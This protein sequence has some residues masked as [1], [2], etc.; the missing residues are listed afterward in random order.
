MNRL[1]ARWPLLLLLGLLIL[2]LF[3]ALRAAATT[4]IPT[5]QQQRSHAV[6]S[7]VINEVDVDTPGADSAEFIELYDGGVGN[8]PL[9]GLVLVLYNG[10]TDSSYAAFDLDG[11]STNA[12]G[13]IVI[14]N[15]GVNLVSATFPTDTLQQGADAV[16]LFQSD[17]TNFGNGTPITTTNLLDALIYDT[18]DPDDNGL[19][20][21]LNA[22]QPQI[23]EAGAGDSTAVSNQRCPNG[24]G[25]QRN[26]TTYTQ[27]FPS[28]GLSNTCSG[29]TPTATATATP[30]SA[31]TP[32]PTVTPTST[33]PTGVGVTA[34]AGATGIVG[35]QVLLPLQIINNNGG[36]SLLG[37]EFQLN[38]NPAVLESL[39][40]ST[41]NTLSADWQVTINNTTP[42]QLHVAG[43]GITPFS[44][45]GVL[46]NLHFQVTQTVN[47]TSALT[48]GDF[49]WNEG[50]PTASTQAGD[51]RTRMLG[52]GGT[53]LYGVS[54]EPVPQVALALTGAQSANATTN[55]QGAYHF[56]LAGT[57][58]ISVTLSKTGDNG[59][60]L[61]ALDA[62]WIL[63]CTVN[64]RPT[65][66]C[67]L[68]AGDSS[69]DGQVSA[70]DAALIARH[71]VGFTTPPSLAGQWRF[72]PP[73]RS[74]PTLTT[75]LPQEDYTAYLVGDV[76]GNWV[77]NGT[78][79]SATTIEPTALRSS[80]TRTGAQARMALW[81]DPMVA[82][83]GYQLTVQYNPATVQFSAVEPTSARSASWQSVANT[84][85]PGVVQV[86]G[87]GAAPLSS[88]DGEVM[89]TLLFQAND[90][91]DPTTDLWL[92]T[93]QIN[94]EQLF[95]PPPVLTA[96]QRLFFPLVI[97]KQ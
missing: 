19:L 27:G 17:A 8:T 36:T 29:A 33:P 39:G 53:V 6:T 21:L 47:V 87:Y 64:L 38:Y 16:A 24:S 92:Q 61:S 3:P 9:N 60:A 91:F 75:D 1:T 11:Y 14:G 90:A 73:S 88:A 80:I 37:Y 22:G 25:G 49:R 71:L 35:G 68:A 84:V 97:T 94:E 67:P 44:G 76:T 69:G 74:Y 32:T 54:G 58:A 13:Y 51:F 65:A 93:V 96:P 40:V 50:Q 95:A 23:N 7:L 26:T 12:N 15:A 85:A 72:T 45:D 81:V 57:G 41:T 52:I 83:L 48:F 28:P 86:A 82:V 79:R 70:Y 20:V 77:S 56:N 34:P 5:P 46:L 42:G 89:V 31:T 2:F 66:A 43:Y 62:A 10:S 30:S 59:R 55:A 18:S 78:V 63:Q 4:M